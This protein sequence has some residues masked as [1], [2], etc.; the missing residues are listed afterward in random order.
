MKYTTD[1]T[2]RQRNFILEKFPEIFNTKSRLTYL[3]FLMPY[4]T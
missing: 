1:L 4:F 3:R 2:L